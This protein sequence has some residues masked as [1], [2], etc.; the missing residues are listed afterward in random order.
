MKANS[1]KSRKR[2][3]KRKIS[4]EILQTEVLNVE[5]PIVTDVIAETNTSIDL[6]KIR[7]PLTIEGTKGHINYY[8]KQTI[9]TGTYYFEVFVRSLEFNIHEYIS[10]KRVDEYS[11]KYYDS[12]LSNIKQYVP[13]VRIGLVHEKGDKDLPMGAEPYSYGYRARDGAIIH[14]GEIINLNKSYAKGDII[15]VLVNLKPPMPDFLKNTVPQDKN[16]E[17]NIKYYLNGIKQD[18]EFVGIT[19][20][21]YHACVTLYNFAEASINFG[22]NFQFYIKEDDKLIKPFLETIL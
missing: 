11:K 4:D 15:G 12:L 19:E 22:P 18:Y 21:N 3:A 6:E 7:K 20:G 16:I 17:C 8:S 14:D 1:R 13:N 2:L 10:S 9:S 5:Q